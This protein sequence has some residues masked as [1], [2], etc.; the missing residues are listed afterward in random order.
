M[1][2]AAEPTLKLVKLDVSGSGTSPA[3][4]DFSTR[5][6]VKVFG[7]LLSSISGVER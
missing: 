4:I 6:L 7:T 1:V 2:E 5:I 3:Y